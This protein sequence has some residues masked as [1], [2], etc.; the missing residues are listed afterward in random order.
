MASGPPGPVG[1]PALYPVEVAPGREQGTAL[2]LLP[3]ME[4]T[5]VKGVMSRAIFVIVTLVQVSVGNS[6]S[7]LYFLKVSLWPLSP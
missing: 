4:A 3:S 6:E 1:V 2:I 7:T 5:N